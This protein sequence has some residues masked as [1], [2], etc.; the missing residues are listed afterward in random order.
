VP[1][2]LD[3]RQLRK[4][5]G[6]TP[7]LRGVD[8]QLGA[9]QLVGVV[10]ENGSG[11]STLL[12]IAVGLLRADSG[13]LQRSGR[14]GYCPQEPWL[15]QALTMRETFR[16]FAQAYRVRDWQS[17]LEALAGRFGFEPHLDKLNSQLSGGTLQ[18]LNLSIALMHEPEL[19]ILDEP[20]TG[21]DWDTY[22]RFWDYSGALK[23]RGCSLLVVSHLVYDRERFDAIYSLKDGI[24]TC[25]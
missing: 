21:F 3:A 13:S 6:R 11:K 10:G 19:L 14:L 5:Y 23:A 4:A 8:L 7:V 20:Y 12:R 2:L 16:Y 1:L 15:F 17:R 18:K 24:L 22:Q 9:G 25:D